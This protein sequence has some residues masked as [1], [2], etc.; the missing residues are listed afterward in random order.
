MPVELPEEA[1]RWS[2]EK[3]RLVADVLAGRTVVVNVRHYREWLDHQPQLCRRLG[4]GELT[5]KAL[6]C[7]CA[8]LPCHADVLAERADR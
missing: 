6:G 8:P 5:G 3:S 4:G 1:V 2:D 7:G